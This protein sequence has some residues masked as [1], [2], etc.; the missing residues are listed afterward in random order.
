[1]VVVKKATADL[2]EQIYPLLRSFDK[3]KVGRDEWRRAFGLRWSSLHDHFGY[4][5]MDGDR[6]VG[7][8]GALFHEREINGKVY[9]FATRMAGSSRSNTVNRAFFS[10]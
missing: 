3:R 1:M 2:F 8:L 7:F 5:L 4:V 10:S 9:N 6:V